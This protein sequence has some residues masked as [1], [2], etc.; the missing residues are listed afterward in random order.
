[1]SSESI[2]VRW[3]AG[4]V[5]EVMIQPVGG[6]DRCFYIGKKFLCGGVEVVVMF[7]DPEPRGDFIIVRGLTSNIKARVS[8]SDLTEIEI[9]RTN[10]RPME[11][12][13]EHGH[14]DGC[15]H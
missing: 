12:H 5:A 11:L 4:E 3:C 7:I 9:S 13:E 14:P 15:S 1:M 2:L 6:G 8:P 10:I